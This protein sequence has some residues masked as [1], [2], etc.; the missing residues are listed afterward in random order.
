MNWTPTVKTK[1]FE[2]IPS[3]TGEA[4]VISDRVTSK[5]S[6]FGVFA[7]RSDAQDKA[8]DANHI[9]DA[10]CEAKRD[11]MKFGH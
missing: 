1:R 4:F 8:D 10:H 5:P 11:I 3:E 9:W 2:V 6:G 7:T